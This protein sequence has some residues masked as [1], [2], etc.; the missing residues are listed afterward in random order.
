MIV[1]FVLIFACVL[2]G[3]M[4]YVYRRSIRKIK[5]KRIKSASRRSRTSVN[6]RNIRK[7][8]KE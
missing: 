4:E 6:R 8:N 1:I 5:N 7:I 2:L 3:Y